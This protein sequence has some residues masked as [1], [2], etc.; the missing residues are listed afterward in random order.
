MLLSVVN[1]Q[2]TYWRHI[3]KG[4]L[5][6]FNRTCTVH[7]KYIFALVNQSLFLHHG[8][9][10]LAASLMPGLVIHTWKA[11]IVSLL[12]T[13]GFSAGDRADQR[14][15]VSFNLVKWKGRCK[16]G[17]SSWG[18]SEKLLWPPGQGP[19]SKVPRPDGAYVQP[20]VS[21]CLPWCG[22]S[23]TVTLCCPSRGPCPH[24]G[25]FHH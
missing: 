1:P 14:L 3:F 24:S 20:V 18:C 4:F 19:C 17:T 15:R 21:L 25:P 11:L 5:F 7:S 6:F 13:L 9:Y 22:P 8:K 12:T 2:L 23:P 10:F 16:V